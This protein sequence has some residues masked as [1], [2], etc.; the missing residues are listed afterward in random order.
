[1]SS[2][3]ADGLGNTVI[4]I[5]MKEY[6]FFKALITIFVSAVILASVLITFSPG[7][8]YIDRYEAVSQPDTATE[9]GPKKYVGIVAGHYGFDTG[10]QCGA[11]LNFVRETDV[12]LRLAVMVRDYLTNMG[13]SVDLLQEFD[14]ALSNYT[15]LALVS[16]HTNRC[17]TTDKSQSGFYVTGGGPNTYPSETKRLNDCLAFNYEKYTGLDYLG[18]NYDTADQMLY[19]FDTVNDY[20]TVSVIH[21]GF[22][23]NDYR[24]FSEQTAS[25]AKGIAEGII[26]YVDDGTIGTIVTNSEAE[27]AAD[28]GSSTTLYKIPLSSAMSAEI[29]K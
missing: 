10:Y 25:L 17:D 18:Q 15:G 2:V 20:T 23:S 3:F 24:A 4:L 21:T 19:V 29:N 26:C 9:T 5:R 22:L 13:Y 7:E 14:P 28:S 8:Q 11:D 27:K 1:M 16:I 6:S 12:D